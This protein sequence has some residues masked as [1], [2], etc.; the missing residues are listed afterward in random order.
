MQ[1]LLIG[2]LD[3]VES[4]FIIRYTFIM[5]I[6]FAIIAPALVLGSTGTSDGGKDLVNIEIEEDV[7]PPLD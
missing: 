4:C 3:C 7:E 2:R 5:F 6:Y 1:I